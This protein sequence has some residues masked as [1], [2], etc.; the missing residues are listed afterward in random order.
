MN[1]SGQSENKPWLQGVVTHRYRVIF[2]DTDQ[3][4]VVYYANYLRFFERGRVAYLRNVGFSYTD[5]QNSDRQLPVVDVHAKYH[6]PAHYEDLLE[7][8]TWMSVLGKARITFNYRIFRLEAEGERTLLNEGATT[9][10]CIGLEGRPKRLPQGLV[11]HLTAYWSS[12]KSLE[13]REILEA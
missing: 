7:V 5:F 4:N 6:R 9:H 2:G 8:E 1:I 3:M 10:A 12:A 11:D 13:Q